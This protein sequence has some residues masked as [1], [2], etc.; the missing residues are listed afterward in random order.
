MILITPDVKE[1]LLSR[2]CCQ[3]FLSLNFPLARD[4]QQNEHENLRNFIKFQLLIDKIVQKTNFAKLTST[5][6][7]FCELQIFQI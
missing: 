2:F 7:L 3:D 5:K 4:T 6:W 1:Y